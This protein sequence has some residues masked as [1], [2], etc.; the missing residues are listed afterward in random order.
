MKN[1]SFTYYVLSYLFFS[2]CVVKAQI[3]MVDPLEP[4][5]PDSNNLSSYSSIWENY[6]PLNT[7][8]DV[9]IVAELPPSYEYKINAS[10]N[11]EELNNVLSKL[12]HVPVEENTGLDSRT[13]QFTGQINPYV[14]RRSPFRIYEVIKPLK[15]QIF[16]VQNTYTAFRL[17]IPEQMIT[18]PGKY[19]III[20]I[21]GDEI[22]EIG[23]FIFHILPVELPKLSESKFFYT[24]WFNLNRMEEKHGV[25]RWTD[26]WFLMLE[27]YA[28]LM[29]HGR[30]NSITIP[31]ELF[32]YADDKFSLDE[33]KLL[34]FIDVFR[35]SG[36]Q[37]FESPHLL[38]RGD[39]DDWNDPELKVVLT[40]RRFYRENGNDDIRQI[41]ELIKDFTKSNNLSNN[42]LQHIADEPTTINA[43]CYKDAV[44]LVK[45]I[46]PE[47]KIMEA[48]NAR[49]SLAGAIDIWCPLIND[50]QEN[51]YFF[52][53]RK[54]AG[55]KVL[56]YTCLIPGGEWLNRTLD[57]ER[58]RQVYFG[59]GAAYYNTE[60]YLH[61]GL[62]Q[63]YADPFEQS[64]VKHPSPIAGPTNY[65]P[66][67]DTHI[68]YPGENAPYS[69]LRFEAHR[70]GCEDYE[71]L[72]ILKLENKSQFD[73]LVRQVFR[74]YTDYSLN[75]RD[76]RE[77][78]KKLLEALK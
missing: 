17:E 4:I 55:E 75:I 48:T 54:N 76:Y 36:F 41:V 62:N 29:A 31:N 7:I 58:L 60:G 8:A 20:Q 59:W 64:V 57:M 15:N 2:I 32:Q 16:K 44:K 1:G 73:H 51:E 22:K 12:I 19:E 18:S 13:E 72:Q 30:Q 28:S 69:S 9:H 61:W 65:L 68:I 3:W 56:V 38:Y 27:K 6:F 53:E 63:Y 52:K 70:I 11:G 37:Y 77:T 23:K 21:E 43:A 67:G 42:W 14:I 35:K 24:N 39:E 26:P 46:F 66:A 33:S 50:F 5:Y 47:I 74:S 45:S 71:L 40:K 78:R 10:L 49:D 34:K 25:K